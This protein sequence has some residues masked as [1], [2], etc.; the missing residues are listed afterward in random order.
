MSTPVPESTVLFSPARIAEVAEEAMV[1]KAL[2]RPLQIVAL[3]LLGGGWIALGFV[4]FVTTQTGAAGLPWG[5]TRLVGGVVFATGLFLVVVTGADLFTSTTMTL[6]GRAAGRLT[7][8]QLLKHWVLVY[9]GNF[10][11][12]ATM[13]AL[14][15]FGGL[16]HQANN[17]WGQVVLNAANGKVH[18]T[19]IESFV[20]GIF[21]NLCVCVAVWAGFAGR[22]L[23]DK[24]VA[25]VGPVALFVATGMEHSIAN[26]FLIPLAI[27]IKDFGGEPFQAMV[28]YDALTWSNLVVKNLIPV[29]LGNIVGGGVMIG[30][31]NWAIQRWRAGKH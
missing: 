26:M 29:T 27:V 25:V 5:L 7:W 2:H 9:V 15:F 18:H 17:G 14:C 28:G 22:S 13:V 4:F 8:W 23:T 21:C 30:L 31:M 16:H 6:I 20:L 24:A 12:A 3:S 10:L 1:T 19:W 11:G